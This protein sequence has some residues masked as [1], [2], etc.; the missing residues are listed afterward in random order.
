MQRPRG[1]TDT[2]IWIIAGVTDMRCGFNGL[3]SGVQNTLKDDPFSGYISI[4]RGRSGKMVK[5]LWA[6]RDGMCLFARRL[7]QGRF[8]WPV[9][10]ERNVYLTLAQLSM[11][12]ESIA[13]QHPKRTER[14]DIRI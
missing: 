9:T 11:L 14:P 10:R 5:I 12:L 4:F 13:W 7:E 3:A 8:V 6:D 1:V 2:R